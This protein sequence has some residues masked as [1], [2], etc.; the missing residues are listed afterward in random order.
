[1]PAALH[2]GSVGGISDDALRPVGTL[3]G[4]LARARPRLGSSPTRVAERRPRH[5]GYGD[6]AST[7]ARL[8]SLGVRVAHGVDATALA[9]REGSPSNAYGLIPPPPSGLW[10]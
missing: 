1:M 6:A 5:A 7:L 2:G 3:P 4:A 9:G 8:G 10:K